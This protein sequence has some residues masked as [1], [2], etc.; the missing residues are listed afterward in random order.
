[1][2]GKIAQG[3]KENAGDIAGDLRGGLAKLQD[4]VAPPHVSRADDDG[5][6]DGDGD[7]DSEEELKQTPRARVGFGAM[8]S[9]IVAPTALESE[10]DDDDD[11]DEEEEEDDDFVQVEES[12]ED[13]QHV[14]SSTVAA[15]STPFES[16]LPQH[17]PVKPQ[18]TT[19]RLLVPPRTPTITKKLV[20]P[21]VGV[22]KP[23]SSPSPV[24]KKLIVPSKPYSPSDRKSVV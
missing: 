12:V 22:T 6:D 4:V 13:L 8:L 24:A 3:L 17:Q 16:S 11:D 14:P 5:D 1:M 7:D 15:S 18:S 9:R 23:A 21:S 2:W 20:V 19:P 10:Y